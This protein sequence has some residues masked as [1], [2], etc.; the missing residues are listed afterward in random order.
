MNVTCV[1]VF[2]KEEHVDDFIA[3]TIPNHEGALEEP[4][5]LRFDV[6]QSVDDPTRFMLTLKPRPDGVYEG[7]LL[8]AAGDS[9]PV[10]MRPAADGQTLDFVLE[11][12]GL[13]G[14][15]ERRLTARRLGETVPLLEAQT[16]VVLPPGEEY[17]VPLIAPLE[18][19]QAEEVVMTLEVADRSPSAAAA[20]E[21]Y[22]SR[23]LPTTIGP[24][25]ST[26]LRV[27]PLSHDVLI[28]ANA[29]AL[30]TLPDQ[31]AFEVTV[32]RAESQGIVAG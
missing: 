28:A 3:A 29:K 1:T 26:M 22:L 4:G 7:R 25:L 19:R 24:P 11:W 31:V 16:E 27:D 13:R 9:F 8:V 2:V 15:S 32:K 5:N 20:R 17:D 12:P 6:L 21:I 23:S 14:R 10:R 18:F 30:R